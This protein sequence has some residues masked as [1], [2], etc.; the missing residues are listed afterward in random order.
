[1]PDEDE[2]RLEELGE[3]AREA[4][5]VETQMGW[6]GDV[7]LCTDC[8]CQRFQDDAPDGLCDCCR[9]GDHLT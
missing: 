3:L 7:C 9:A 4:I 1:M 5:D 2:G 8:V 6:D